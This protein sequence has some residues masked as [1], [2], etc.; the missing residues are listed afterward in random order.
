VHS[1]FRRQR[2]GS[3][4]DQVLAAVKQQ[5]DAADQAL[6]HSQGGCSTKIHIRTEGYGKPLTIMLT[7]GK[8]YEAAVVDRLLN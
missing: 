1:R 3:I 7:P 4:W 8:Q 6:G 2:I 5:V